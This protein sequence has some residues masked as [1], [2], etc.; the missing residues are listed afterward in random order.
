[1]R[2]VTW[3][4]LCERDILENF[5]CGRKTYQMLLHSLLKWQNV[6]Q[7]LNNVTIR[8]RKKSLIFEQNYT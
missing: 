1:M 7:D 5:N 6:S 8:M 3:V 4:Y 2:C